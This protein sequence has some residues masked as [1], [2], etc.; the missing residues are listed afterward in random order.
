MSDFDDDFEDS[1][2][3]SSMTDNDLFSDDDDEP[4]TKRPRHSEDEPE[5]SEPETDDEDYDDETQR[6]QNLLRQERLKDLYR[7][8]THEEDGET[9]EVKIYADSP[10]FWY[11]NR[12][13]CSAITE[14]N[15]AEQFTRIFFTKDNF[16]TIM[17]TGTGAKTQGWFFNGIIW[18]EMDD[19]NSF[20]TQSRFKELKD[21]Y[22]EVW[23][24]F[25]SLMPSLDN[26]Q[27]DS[28][29]KSLQ[30]LSKMTFVKNVVT[31]IIRENHHQEKITWNANKNLWAFEDCIYDFEQE[32]FLASSNPNDYINK[33]CGWSYN[34][35]HDPIELDKAREYVTSIVLDICGNDEAFAN[36]ILTEFA[37]SMKGVNF[38]ERM[39][40]L[41]GPGRNGKGT[42]MCLF[43]LTLGDYYGTM[44]IE[45][46]SEK[47]GKSG[48]A[49]VQLAAVHDK[50]VVGIS[51]TDK[52]NEKA[53][54]FRLDKF[55]KATGRDIITTRDN[56]AKAKDVLNFELPPC[57][58]QCNDMP[59]INGIHN[60]K[61]QSLQQRVVI[62]LFP[63]VYT[64]DIEKIRGE[65]NKYKQIN[66]TIKDTLKGKDQALYRRVFFDILIEH[67][68]QYQQDKSEGKDR[69]LPEA[70]KRTRAQYFADCDA[71]KTLFFDTFE[72]HPQVDFPPP[73]QRETY[74]VN[75]A[76]E[77]F[78]EAFIFK[79]KMS[80]A[81]Y[82]EELTRIIGERPKG[83][84]KKTARG[85]YTH[86]GNK[87][88]QGYRFKSD[89]DDP[90]ADFDADARRQQQVQA[91][92][93]RYNLQQVEYTPV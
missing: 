90:P 52:V 31:W 13:N 17:F 48:A 39:L 72:E 88:I 30:D 59:H 33:T 91:T 23:T 70:L 81:K 7:V 3:V 34:F 71:V 28:V 8:E 37:I 6:Q 66:V 1:S 20:L 11:D 80:K 83:I 63:H 58:T 79:C 47:P 4:L 42:V 41:L 10:D 15:V 75:K 46:F 18:K 76:F 53:T 38:L 36:F 16:V 5:S 44:E 93:A 68:K 27:I 77:K 64:N 14:P 35:E 61:N 82:T 19:T 73:C 43:T 87:Y 22:V 65:P 26:K 51:E 85:V 49:N 56:H 45:W 78:Q 50:R 29:N 89:T 62:A 24:L 21:T 67:L 12:I 84:H 57:I 40:F 74:S 86:D 92:Q 9:T 2:Q 54:D 60:E 69:E 55:K 32:K 25:Q